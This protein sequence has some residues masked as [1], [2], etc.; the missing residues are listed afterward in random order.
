MLWTHGMVQDLAPRLPVNLVLPAR[1]SRVALAI[2]VSALTFR[3]LCHVAVHAHPRSMTLGYR[4]VFRKNANIQLCREHIPAFAHLHGNG[5]GVHR[6]RPVSERTNF[7]GLADHDA[8]TAD[9]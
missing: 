5:D 4:A 3:P 6:R 1:L 8:F 7:I 2:Q 9:V